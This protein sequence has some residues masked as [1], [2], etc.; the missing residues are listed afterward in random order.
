M[1]WQKKLTREPENVIVMYIYIPKALGFKKYTVFTRN[2]AY[3][4]KSASLELALPPPSPFWREIFNERSL[5]WAPISS[6]KRGARLKNSIY[7]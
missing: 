1:E 7:S 5:V 4:R 6:L 3:A 2:S